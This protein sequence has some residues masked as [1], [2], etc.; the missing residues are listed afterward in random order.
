MGLLSKV[1][2]IT[3]IVKQKS[4]GAIAT[5]RQNSV[6]A[7][8]GKV[9]LGTGKVGLSAVKFV[10]KKSPIGTA[11]AVGGLAYAGAKKIFGRKATT[12]VVQTAQ[13]KGIVS[14][15]IEF[16][17]EH[18]IVATAGLGAGAY[19]AE[20][21]AEK[22]GVRGGAGFIGK[23]PKKK[24]K[25]GKRRKARGYRRARRV[26]GTGRRVSFTTRDGRRV[27]FIPRA[28]KS[29]LRYHRKRG[30]RGRGVS[31]TELRSL[32]AML[33]RYERD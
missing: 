1:K 4:T 9:A 14:R 18:P 2:T 31:R 13:K 22:L 3:G 7:K 27:S 32:R 21:V 26:R 15:A 20:Q 30:R 17:K 16:A 8:V 12:Q 5:L 28:R 25:G 11:L 6:I 33:R 24:R 23:R 29:T 10:A 19:V